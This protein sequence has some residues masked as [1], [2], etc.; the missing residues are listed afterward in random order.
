MSLDF[1]TI[2]AGPQKGYKNKREPSISPTSY[3]KNQTSF[4][5]DKRTSHGE[6]Q[7]SSLRK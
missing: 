4:L 1:N 7:K 5:S 3:F 6:I 2:I